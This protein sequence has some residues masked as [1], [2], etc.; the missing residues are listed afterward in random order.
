[1][2]SGGNKTF[3]IYWYRGGIL[4]NSTPSYNSDD[5]LKHNESPIE[6]A[7]TAIN[8]IEVRS[9]FRTFTHHKAEHNFELDDE[10]NPITDE[11]YVHEVGVIAQQL[12]TIDGFRKKVTSSEE[13]AQQSDEGE[14][15]TVTTLSVN[16]NDIFM[17]NVQATQEL[18]RH[19]QADKAKIAELE[20]EVATLKSELA[21]I[22]SHLGI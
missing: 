2:L 15:E 7:L 21:A 1:M 12:Q 14:Q 11:E 13:P 5:R 18:Y 22:K 20:N 16:Y 17:Y 4:F 6:N 19:Q 8:Q 10:G 3:Y 9:Y